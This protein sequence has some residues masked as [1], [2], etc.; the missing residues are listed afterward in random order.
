MSLNYNKLMNSGINRLREI[1]KRFGSDLKSSRY[2]HHFQ[3]PITKILGINA[4]VF[5]LLH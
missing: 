4:V 5:V 2:S 3:S 1:L